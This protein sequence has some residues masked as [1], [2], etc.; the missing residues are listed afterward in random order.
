M[1]FVLPR[2]R[3]FLTYPRHFLRKYG[4]SLQRQNH[5]RA[6]PSVQPLGRVYSTGLLSN[7]LCTYNVVLA[8]WD[9][10]TQFADPLWKFVLAEDTGETISANILQESCPFFGIFA[11]L[12]YLSVSKSFRSFQAPCSALEQGALSLELLV[13]SH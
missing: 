10:S 9:V 2:Y 11:T 7:L 3:F 8:R 5:T 12:F 1:C 13:R 4:Q 6:V